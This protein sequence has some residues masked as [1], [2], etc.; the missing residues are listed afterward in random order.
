MA[1]LGWYMRTLKPEFEQMEKEGMRPKNIW[2]S[3]MAPKNDEYS[4]LRRNRI[5][6]EQCDQMTRLFF[7]MGPFITMEISP[8]AYQFTKDC[9]KFCQI[10]I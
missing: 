3:Q 6:F 4:N 9:I 5:G 8:K 7:N 1:R 2:V 10:L